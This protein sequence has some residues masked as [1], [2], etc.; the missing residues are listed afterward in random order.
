M[1]F[2]LICEILPLVSVRHHIHKNRFPFVSP[3]N[4]AFL[5]R[6]STEKNT[7]KEKPR[8]KDFFI[9]IMTDTI[10]RE[11]AENACHFGHK[12][13]R[14]NPKMAPY[15]WGKKGGIHIFDL[16]KTATGLDRVTKIIKDLSADGKTILFVSTKPQT[17]AVLKEIKEKKGHPIVANKWVGGLLTNFDTI[18]TRIRRL[19]DIR[20]MISTNDIEK[21]PKKEQAQ[22]RKEGEKLEVA[23]GGIDD[24]YRAPDTIFIVDG[25]RDEIAIREANRLGIP[26]YGI[27]DSNVKPDLYHDFIPANDDAVTSLSYLLGKVFD[28]LAKRKTGKRG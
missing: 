18:K 14:W 7:P 16:E 15:L 22:I 27:A 8:F 25:C 10:L 6:S 13:S 11:L 20:E 23:F 17:K 21:F 1:L 28:A 26:V 9:N 4:P 2:L 19:K 12:V 5:E 3:P 24:L